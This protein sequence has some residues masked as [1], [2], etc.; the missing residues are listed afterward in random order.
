MLAFFL[1]AAAPED[2]LPQPISAAIAP[3]PAA[4]AV[5]HLLLQP[6]ADATATQLG[7]PAWDGSA[8]ALRRLQA[9]HAA[10]LVLLDG[11]TLATLCKAQVTD[12]MDWAVLGR[13]RF[14]ANA[15]TDCGAGAYT[16]ATVLAWDR[17]K[18]A[19]T[20][21]WMD[22]WDIAKHPGRRGLRR[23]ARGNLEL[24]LLAD[25]VSA[26]DVYRSLRSNDG[27]DRAFRKL[28]QLK[29]YVL[30]WD[31]PEQPGQLL[32]QAKVLLTSAPSA[33]LPAGA[34]AHVGTQW[35]GSLTEIT[36]WARL[37]GA[38]HGQGAAAAL[39]VATDPARLASLARA[40]GL[41][42]STKA[43]IAL[44]PAD[45][46]TQNPSTPANQQGALAIDD[47]FWAEN[48]DRLEARFVA[49]VGK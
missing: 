26:A 31:K 30:W 8:D 19:G 11:G 33:S 14:V 49:W 16:S 7:A 28:D 36:F 40:S 46:R 43:A 4:E 32:A 5:R 18:L 17:D 2:T 10:D 25:G 21:G 24:A 42:P 38:P 41:G 3:G 48:A 45:V 35:D 15:S 47:G 6:Y 29:P 9:A 34:K 44:L 37:A 12:R 20:P 13:D 23:G 22:F 27:V 39:I 1:L